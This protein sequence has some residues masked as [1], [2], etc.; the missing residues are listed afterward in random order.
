MVDFMKAF[1]LVD[2]SLLLKK[3]AIYKCGNNFIRLMES[4][5][6]NRTQVVSVN[7]KTSETD[8]VTCGVPQGSILGPLLFLLFINDLPLVL[9]DKVSSTDLYADDTTIYDAQKS[10]LQDDLISLHE[11]C[12][13][14]GM[15]LNTEKTKIMIIT[16]R[17]KRLHIDES[18]LSL[19]YNDVDLE[20]TTGDKI[21][22]INID[23]NLT[24]SDHF[25]FVYK[26]VSTCVWLLSKI[27]SYLNYEH[28]VMFY[29]AYIQP[30]FNYCNVI[31][32]NSSNYNLSRV[33]KL[34]KRAF[35][36]ILGNDYLDFENA[37]MR[38]N[39]LSFEQSVCK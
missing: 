18:I 8:N 24:W 12:K 38:L 17:Q 25:H 16:T 3:L 29:N 6:D 39:I 30:H 9:S 26:K 19:S 33:N 23:A 22:G 10:N 13:Q 7:N 11:W 14:T 20:I 2:H 28:K 36:I 21:L 37:K 34:E 1:D 4:Y 27:S 35:K 5:L 31:W 32:D 15:L